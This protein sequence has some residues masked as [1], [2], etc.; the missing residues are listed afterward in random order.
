MLGRR[1]L[2]FTLLFMAICPGWARAQNRVA[3][4]YALPVDGTWVE[5]EWRL[6][7]ADKEE[8]GTLRINSVGGKEV[9]GNRYRWVE[10]KTETRAGDKKQSQH[11]KLLVAENAFRAGQ[12]LAE[13]VSECY[14]QDGAS[15]TVTRLSGRRLHDFLSLGLGEGVSFREV[16][17][18]EEVVTKLG[19]Y[20]A[21]HVS[22]TGLVGEVSR[23]YHAW[24][25]SEVPFG[26]AK[27]TVHEKG[28]KG[29]ERAFAAVA[30]QSGR[31]AKSEVDESRAQ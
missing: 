7:T 10:I 9:G 2:L 17:A 25:T 3:P 24:L 12:P 16:Q 15:R 29:A 28:S 6:T 19:K 18:K 11:R 1:C 21:R 13:C 5:F 27:L 20:L 8:K 4:F 30:T 31:G 26:I 22:A 23:E 14:H